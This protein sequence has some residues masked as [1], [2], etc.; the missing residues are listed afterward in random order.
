MCVVLLMLPATNTDT[1]A[2]YA[3]YGY[4]TN[5]NILEWRSEGLLILWST[6][7]SRLYSSS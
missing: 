6:V 3:I 4:K 1:A 2:L 7:L 5:S